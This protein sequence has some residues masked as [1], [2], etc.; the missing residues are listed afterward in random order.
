MRSASFFTMMNT[1][2]TRY[3]QAQKSNRWPNLF[4]P[5][6]TIG[7]IL[8][9]F[10]CVDE[11]SEA[12]TAILGLVENPKLGVLEISEEEYNKLSQ[13]KTATLGSSQG[14]KPRPVRPLASLVDLVGEESKGATTNIPAGVTPTGGVLKGK[15]TAQVDTAGTTPEPEALPA[16]RP[17]PSLAEALQ[18]GEVDPPPTA[19]PRN[20]RKT[21]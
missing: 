20:S 7:G 12:L 19:K 13:K 9:G 8:Y 10:T 18:T 1:V 3:F 21:K 11:P 14:F 2:K 16:G 4:E 17:V 15:G 6:D 5:F